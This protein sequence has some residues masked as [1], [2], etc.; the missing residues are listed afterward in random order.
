[1]VFRLLSYAF[2][3]FLYAY[4]YGEIGYGTDAAQTWMDACYMLIVASSIYTLTVLP[5]MIIQKRL[6]YKEWSQGY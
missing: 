6:F 2:L 5:S 4:S 1:V 3:G